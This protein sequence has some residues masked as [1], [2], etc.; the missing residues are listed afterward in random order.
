MIRRHKPGSTLPKATNRDERRKH[1][2]RDHPRADHNESDTSVPASAA[3]DADD[4]RFEQDPAPVDELDS[5]V[6]D[7]AVRDFLGDFGLDDDEAV[8][9]QGDFC[10]DDAPADDSW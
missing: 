8:P 5:L 1:V 10:F 2:R 4:C 6:F 7:P 9:E 3:A